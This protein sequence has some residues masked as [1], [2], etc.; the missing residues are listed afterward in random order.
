MQKQQE[1]ALLEMFRQ[2][3]EKNRAWIFA[4]SS[5]C[6]NPQQP[7][8]EVLLAVRRSPPRE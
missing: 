5:R 4:L 1:A 7:T 8:A 6:V 2:M 3:T